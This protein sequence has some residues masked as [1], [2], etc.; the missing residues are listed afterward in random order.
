MHRSPD[1]NVGFRS[2]RALA[3]PSRL[4]S[5]VVASLAFAALSLSVI[6]VITVAATQLSMAMPLPL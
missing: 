2:R 4:T 5:A 3:A 6:V 1:A